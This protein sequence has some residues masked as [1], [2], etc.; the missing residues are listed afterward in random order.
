MYLSYHDKYMQPQH[1]EINCKVA[2]YPNH[3][4]QNNNRWANSAFSRLSLAVLIHSYKIMKGHLPYNENRICF[5]D[6]LT[7]PQWKLSYAKPTNQDRTQLQVTTRDLLT[8]LW[9]IPHQ[10]TVVSPHQSGHNKH[11]S[12]ECLHKAINYIRR[13]KAKKHN[14]KYKNPYNTD[15]FLHF[16]APNPHFTI[17]TRTI[18]MP[19]FTV[20]LLHASYPLTHS[21]LFLQLPSVTNSNLQN[22]SQSTTIN[23]HMLFGPVSHHITVIAH[24][25]V[26]IE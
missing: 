23:T 10:L 11:T 7:L 19:I 15:I 24:Q 25:P 21:K 16:L 9:L 20:L 2:S 5:I 17:D 14:I 22:L 8:S 26:I 18:K 6:Y 3:S 1:T 13:N 4:K 12:I